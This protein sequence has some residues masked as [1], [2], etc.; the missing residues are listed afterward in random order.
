MPARTSIPLIGGALAAV[1]SYA[2][3]RLAQG[4]VF[5]DP[6]PALVLYSEHAGYFW[7]MWIAG[8]FGGMV[9]I[10]LLVTD[11]ARVVRALP[12]AVVLAVVLLV[13]QAVLVP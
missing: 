11:P 7:R 3:I 12:G 6:D 10:T 4:L 1:A 13:A 8:F 9:A 5:G 2:L